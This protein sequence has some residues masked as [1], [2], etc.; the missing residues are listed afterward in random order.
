MVSDGCISL[1]P[2]RFISREDMKQILTLISITKI[3]S[4]SSN[5]F[6]YGILMST[7]RRSKKFGTRYNRIISGIYFDVI[8]IVSV[9]VIFY[10]CFESCSDIWIV[11][12]N[13]YSFPKSL[14][15]FSENFICLLFLRE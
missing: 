14:L 10:S 6:I 4:Y 7:K 5:P 12:Y 13:Q 2:S 9:I 15:F 3:F 11:V 1:S 8:S